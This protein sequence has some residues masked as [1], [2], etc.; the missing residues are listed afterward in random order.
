MPP[1][2][3]GEEVLG[4]EGDACKLWATYLG[5]A[6]LNEACTEPTGTT[7]AP[8][9]GSGP[10]PTVSWSTGERP[11]RHK[12]RTC[13]GLGMEA[14]YVRARSFPGSPRGATPGQC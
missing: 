4:K 7:Q 12:G 11:P 1:R 6:V 14:E 9:C 5:C 10:T 2:G 13:V 3:Q 8:L